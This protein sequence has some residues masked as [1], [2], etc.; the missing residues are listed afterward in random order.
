MTRQVWA[1]CPGSCGE[2]FQIPYQD[3]ELLL[4][5]A[6]DR[7]ATV[8]IRKQTFGETG[9]PV[10]PKMAQALQQFEQGKKLQ[11]AHVTNIPLS[12]GCSSSTADIL[13]VFQACSYYQGRRLSADE[14]T[15]RAC[16]IEPTDSLAFRNWTVI[17][18]LTGQVVWETDWQPTLGVYILEPC[19]RVDTL[20]IERQ[21]K[22]S[23][24][25]LES[26]AEIF[27]LFQKAC[28]DR[29][30][31][32]LGYLATLSGTLNNQRLPK[33]FFKELEILVQ[34]FGFLGINVAHSGTVLGI[35]LRPEQKADL[36]AFEH[37]IMNHSIGQYYTK[38][39]YSSIHFKGI[40]LGED[41]G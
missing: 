3:Q 30:V 1:R 23:T 26:A 34:S 12:K 36:E 31:E 4:S 24:Y 2:L 20:E 11:I 21:P 16:R 13:A 9:T 33:P 5:Y 38:R 14:V 19:E 8:K 27:P 39:Y 22:S 25:S 10:M 7:Y 29:D 15:R 17:N 35:L 32:L 28:Q 41:D 37:Q 6:I 18:P 40:E